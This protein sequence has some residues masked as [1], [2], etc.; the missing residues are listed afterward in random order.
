MRVFLL[1][2]PCSSVALG[3]SVGRAVGRVVCRLV[4]RLL[5]VSLRR[6]LC[7]WVA[8]VGQVVAQV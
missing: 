3:R 1:R 2:V 7:G 6:L 4:R 5:W 8:V